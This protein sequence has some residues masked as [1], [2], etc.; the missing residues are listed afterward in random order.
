MNFKRHLPTASQYVSVYQVISLA[1]FLLMVAPVAFA[2]EPMSC[3]SP[4][5][6][7][8][9]AKQWLFRGVR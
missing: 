5:A 2:G 7:E 8:H 6:F 1:P 3:A 4:G 9:S